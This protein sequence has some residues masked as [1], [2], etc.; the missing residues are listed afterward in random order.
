LIKIFIFSLG[1]G[2]IVF[3]TVYY[4]AYQDLLTHQPGSPH[5]V[6]SANA[7][8]YPP[9]AAWIEAL[10]PALLTFLIVWALLAHFRRLKKKKARR[11]RTKN[12]EKLSLYL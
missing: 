8:S 6:Y 3:G 9:S 2:G 11:K 1:T 4:L 12:K 7:T 10:P 5:F